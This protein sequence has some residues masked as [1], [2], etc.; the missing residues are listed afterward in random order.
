MGLL[1]ENG[2]DL[3][4]LDSGGCPPLQVAYQNDHYAI[5]MLLLEKGG[6]ATWSI[7]TTTE[8]NTSYSFT[9]NSM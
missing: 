3:N 2:A 1:I 9:N 6:N 8:Q 7:P 5:A 4:A